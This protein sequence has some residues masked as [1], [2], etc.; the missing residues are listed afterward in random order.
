MIALRSDRRPIDENACVGVPSPAPPPRS[1]QW[2]IDI[3]QPMSGSC[4]AVEAYCEPRPVPLCDPDVCHGLVS[5]CNT[6]RDVADE[7]RFDLDVLDEEDP[8]EID[9]QRTCSSIRT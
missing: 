8:F 1:A 9:S 5:V 7:E 4:A 6:I 2:M 3:A